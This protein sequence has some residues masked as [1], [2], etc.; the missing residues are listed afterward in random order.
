MN[1]NRLPG[2][3]SRTEWL[4]RIFSR[5]RKQE[6]APQEHPTN[7]QP[8][9]A[10]FSL[11]L[12][13]QASVPRLPTRQQLR[14]FPAALS[15]AE[16]WI[17]RI[18]TIVLLVSAVILLVRFY[19]RHVV[20]LAKPGG[21]YTEAV[22]GSPKFINPVL[23]YTNDV[24][25]DL[26]KLLFRGLYQTNE[27]GEVIH[28]LASHE[29]VADDGKTYI[30]TIRQDAVWHDGTPITTSDVAFTFDAIADP[31]YQSPL[32]STFRGLQVE[33]VDDHT[34]KM[35]LAKPYAPFLSTLT[36]GILPA[37]IWGDI[38]GAS[39]SLAEYNIKPIGSGPFRFDSLT[40][41]RRGTIKAFR[42]VRFERY[43]GPRPF[44]DD[45][46]F[47]FYPTREETL[48][49]IKRHRADGI[50]FVTSEMR[51]EIEE[52]GL[53]LR[54]L[55]LPQYTAVFFN[56]RNPLLKEKVIRQSLERSIDKRAI[57]EQA[58]G[59]A[60]EAI[61]TPILPGFLGYNPAVQGLA[62]DP[63]AAG[64]ALDDAGWALLAGE[65]V[66]KKNGKELQFALST[67]DR[68]EYTKTVELLRAFWTKIGVGLEVRLFSSS[69]IIKKVVKPRDYEAL[70][71]GEIIGADPDP[72]P[73]WHSSQSF[74]PGLNLAIFF[75]KQVDQ[76]LE[77]A[78]QTNDLEQRRMKYLHFQNILADEEPAVFLYNPYYTY[79]LPKKIKGFVLERIT[80][81]SDRFNNIE[82]WYSKTRRGWR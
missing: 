70:L 76:L 7:P 63:Q 47:R 19:Q 56:Q 69:D 68:P 27:K 18:A 17:L 10:L 24:D 80:V 44:L 42:V 8:P 55:R 33:I 61:H 34:I 15:T 73:F 59:G 53:A 48:E 32:L 31:E 79:A 5:F 43:Y 25:L 11:P 12:L 28:D 29:E 9:R 65:T 81:P 3:P 35:T 45:L 37:H 14:Y 6:K 21:S 22:L 74:D 40:K 39:A 1:Q 2:G 23:A 50:S 26:T 62:Y 78:R 41:D 4:S 20:A 82:G 60:G 58:L 30:F 36:V 64:K 38:P 13:S 49:A 67:V 77:E 72:Y 52:E 51:P 16:L 66:R 71:F 75:N 46:T 57:V 54:E